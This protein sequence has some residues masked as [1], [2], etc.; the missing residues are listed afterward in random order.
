M[1]LRAALG[2]PP[3]FP[4]SDGL[5]RG[6]VSVSGLPLGLDIIAPHQLA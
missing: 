3:G 4:D 2:L 5:K 6:A 1:R